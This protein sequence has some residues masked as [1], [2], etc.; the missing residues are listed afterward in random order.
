[1]CYYRSIDRAKAPNQLSTTKENIMTTL[2]IEY[3]SS[4]KAKSGWRS[5]YIVAEAL[6]ISAG[7]CQIVN[8]LTINDKTPGYDSL[9]GA[10]RQEFDGRYFAE[11]QIGAKKLISSLYSVEEI[12]E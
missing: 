12:N 4:V 5:V 11:Q 10:K 7:K 2:K 6:Q 3:K 1:M 9:T 8:V